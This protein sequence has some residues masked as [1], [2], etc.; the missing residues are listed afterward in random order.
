MKSF[1]KMLTAVAVVTFLKLAGAASSFDMEKI[2]EAIAAAVSNG[3]TSGIQ[4]LSGD[5]VTAFFNDENIKEA[6]GTDNS[7][8]I[9]KAINGMMSGD[10]SGFQKLG[11]DGTME[12]IKE[13]LGT[14][15]T[16]KIQE[17]INGLKNGNM[18]GIQKVLNDGT[19]ATR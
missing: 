7:E 3:D 4:Q 15:N 14:E 6:I 19:W 2:Q 16:E 1:K 11:N 13:A 10:M 12:K 17:A 8:N 5:L 18:S 9:Q